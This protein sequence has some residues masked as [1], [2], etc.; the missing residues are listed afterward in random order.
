MEQI[1]MDLLKFVAAFLLSRCV[2]TF[3]LKRRFGGVVIEVWRGG[4]VICRREASWKKGEQIL[5]DAQ[6]WAVYVKSI[7]SPFAFLTVDVTSTEAREIGL[8]EVAE[9]GKY[10]KINLD[11][12]PPP[13]PRGGQAK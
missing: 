11:K 4:Q 8:V 1:M 13:P 5:G 12:N 3:Y 10:V 6:D 2:E 9:G 7:V